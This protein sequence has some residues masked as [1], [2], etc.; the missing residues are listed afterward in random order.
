MHLRVSEK[1]GLRFYLS[2]QDE[3]ASTILQ[4]PNFTLPENTINVETV[5]TT[6]G[7]VFLVLPGS[8]LGLLYGVGPVAFRPWASTGTQLYVIFWWTISNAYM[9]HRSQV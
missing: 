8:P 3:G 6:S 7:I 1:S 2:L 4:Q 9:D 5:L